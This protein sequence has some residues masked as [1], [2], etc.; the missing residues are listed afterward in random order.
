MIITFEGGEGSGK[1]SNAARLCSY[2]STKGL[3]WLSL[4]EPGGSSFSEGARVLFLR[5]EMD[6]MAELLLLLASRRQN[7]KEI[8]E[9]GLK[10]GKIVVMDR[11]VDSTVVY[12]GIVG[13]LGADFTRSIME[14]TMTWMEPDLTF[15]MDVDPRLALSRIKPSDRFENQDMP[16]HIRLREAF[17]SL[18][19]SRTR[20]IDTGL[21]RETVYSNIISEIDVLIAACQDNNCHK[22]T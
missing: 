16:Y 14:Q 10:S 3:P 21:D 1:S 15:I 20:I 7:M 11:F 8:I 22:S 2:L 4:R 6:V 12:Q 17:L 9:P 5:H 18:N 13:G 19:S